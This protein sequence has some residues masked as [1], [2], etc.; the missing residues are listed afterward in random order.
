MKTALVTGGAGFFGDV[1]KRRLLDEGWRCV[2]VDLEEDTVSA[3]GLVSLRGDIR[4]PSIM[5]RAF[6]TQSFDVVYHCA[7]LLAHGGVDRKL[8]WTSNVEGTRSVAEYAQRHGVPRVVFTSSNCLWGEGLG[9]P[10]R[11]DDAP[12]PCEIYG[13][14]KWEGEKILSEYGDAFHSI[15]IRCPTII[16]EGRLGLLSILFEFIHE[17][18][19]IWVVGGGKNR[20]QFVFAQDL[21]SACLL[22]ADHP[23]SDVF[24]IGSDN[25]KTF[26]EVYEWVIERA[27]TRARVASMPALPTL[28]LMKIAYWI[29]LSPLG[30]YQYRMIAED[31][32]FD[33]SKIKS[34]LGWEPTVTNEEMLFRAYAYYAANRE[35]IEARSAAS[36]HRRT[37]KMGL[38]RLLK[39]IS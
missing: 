30:P 29:G 39:W 2:S 15:V 37:A 20:Y 21:A 23:R 28:G 17:G 24:H 5:D 12:A 18:R 33:T 36:A 31:F 1:L 7:A 10:V 6:A 38:I 8:L 22:A 25:V 14:S 16:D 19:R 4:D 34:S 35:E 3:D 9:R 27:G 32:L 26:R 11:E 13:R